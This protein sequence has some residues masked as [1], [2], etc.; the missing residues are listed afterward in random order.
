[1][2]IGGSAPVPNAIVVCHWSGIDGVFGTSDDL[3]LQGTADATGHLSFTGIP[4]GAFECQGTDP[5]SGKQSA[6]KA[7]V[8]DVANSTPVEVLLPI[9][10]AKRYVF[11]VAGFPKG[12]AKMTK[13]MM[14]RILKVMKA[15]P[16]SKRVGIIGYTMGPSVLKVDY[17]LSMTRAK[18]AWA[19][20]RAVDNLSRLISLRSQQVKTRTGSF[21]RRVTI[22]LYFD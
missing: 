15:H 16:G 14:I 2:V 1:V 13:A 6:K 18:V 20:V 10:K 9:K 17:N 22:A 5:V 4:G 19:R 12:S 11:T 7:V 21:I 3:D 8:L